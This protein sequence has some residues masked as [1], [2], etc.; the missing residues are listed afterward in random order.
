MRRTLIGLSVVALVL[1]GCSSDD[2][3][4][5]TTAAA[6]ADSTTTTLPPTTEAETTTTTVA[7]TTTTTA[8]QIPT[9]PVVPGED[10]DAD[11][12]VELFAIVF[13]STSSVEDT[14]PLIVDSEGLEATIEAYNEA[15]E[16][17]GGLFLQVNETGV[18]GENAAVVY[19]LLFAGNPFQTDQR[20]E[21]VNEDDTWKVTRAYFCSIAEL[22]RVPCS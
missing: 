11:E 17:V 14:M 3:S 18:S 19:D 12:I 10:E 20:G 8:P 7:T 6:A 9:T 1:A 2:G 13:D 22:A 15:G 16:G 4:S 5:S 21:A